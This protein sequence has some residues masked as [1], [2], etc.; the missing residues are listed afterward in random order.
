MSVGVVG[1]DAEGLS[2]CIEL[3][4]AGLTGRA[5]DLL[6][7]RLHAAGHAVLLRP[8]RPLY[9]RPARRQV[10]GIAPVV[11]LLKRQA[12]RAVLPAAVLPVGDY[13]A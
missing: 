4:L 1:V 3:G 8:G 7:V 6:A 10:V 11:G 5:T 12:D 13:L 9:N 2:G